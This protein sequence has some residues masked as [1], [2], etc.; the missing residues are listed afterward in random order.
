MFDG[1][2]EMTTEDHLR[3]GK[4]RVARAR[5]KM[6]NS[7]RMADGTVAFCIWGSIVC[8]DDGKET[9]FSEA[10]RDALDRLEMALPKARTLWTAN[11]CGFNNDPATTE[12]QV[13]ALY[14]RALAL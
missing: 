13:Q 7:L 5:C 10:Q 8:D 9:L 2:H 12:E 14:D 1:Q 11:I 6:V 3:R 4:E